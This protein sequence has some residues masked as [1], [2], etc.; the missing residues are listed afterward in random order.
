MADEARVAGVETERLL[1]LG[2]WLA[3]AGVVGILLMSLGEGSGVLHFFITGLLAAIAALVAG[4]LLGVIFGSP[5][6]VGRVVISAKEVAEGGSGARQTDD[7]YSDNAAIDRIATWLTGAIIALGLAN[8]NSWAARFDQAAAEVSTEM[9][10]SGALSAALR[11]AERDV[12]RA[13]AALET[14]RRPHR[15]RRT[16]PN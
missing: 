5:E 14:P 2:C 13:A 4:A 10:A 7:W 12:E 16:T 15:A 8:F 6:T 11:V 9:R 3:L 1:R